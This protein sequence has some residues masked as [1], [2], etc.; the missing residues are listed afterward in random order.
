LSAPPT[1]FFDANL[2]PR[3]ARALCALGED[4]RHI[5]DC[6]ELNI[7]FDSPDETWMPIVAK[8]GWIALTL[9]TNISKRNRAERKA[10]LDCGLRV[11]FLAENFSRA[12]RE[13]FAQ[14]AFFCRHWR[15]LVAAVERARPGDCFRMTESGKIATYDL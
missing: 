12:H 11:V 8:H 2:S 1:F 3:I 9:D 4:V 6:G 15:A 13:L 14:A 7:A 10:L 5:R